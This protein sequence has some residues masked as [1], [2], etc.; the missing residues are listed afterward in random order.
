M[1]Y[2]E[3]N[4]TLEMRKPEDADENIKQ[5]TVLPHWA[6]GLSKGI[7]IHKNLNNNL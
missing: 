5:D 3:A 1:N 7:F 6:T 2:E 4:N